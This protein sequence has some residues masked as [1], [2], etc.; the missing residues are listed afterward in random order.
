MRIALVL[1]L[2]AAPVSAGLLSVQGV[3]VLDGAGAPRAIFSNNERIVFQQ[4]IHNGAASANRI[5]FRF[6]VLSPTGSQVFEHA[7]NAVPGSVG[8]A[9]SQVSG[10]P[11]S[12]FYS[13]PGVYTLK[14]QASLDGSTVE[15]TAS[16]TLSSPNILLV[17]PPNGSRDLSDS[18]LTFRWASSGATRY[19]V[20]VGDNPSFYNS[21]FSQETGSGETFLSYPQNPSDSRQRLS[22]GQIYY[23]KVEGLDANGNAVASSEVPFTFSVLSAAMTKDLAVVLLEI[24]P[25]GGGAGVIPF[26]VSVKN[27]GSTT[28]SNV[29]LRFGIGGVPAPGTPVIIPVLNPGE[30]KDYELPASLPP[31]QGESL[32]IACVEIFDDMVP[33]NCKTLTVSAPK[34]PVPGE[35]KKPIFG[36]S[37]VLGPEQVWQ[38]ISELLKE[39]GLTAELD[40]YSLVGME[41]QL[42]SDELAAL[43]DGL[44]KGEVGV[45]LTGPPPAPIAPP[46]LAPPPAPPAPPPAALPGMAAPPPPPPAPAAPSGAAQAPSGSKSA[47]VGTEW[48]GLALPSGKAAQTLAVDS[49][50]GWERLWKRVGEGTPPELDFEKVMVVGILCGKNDP[51]ERVEI[52]AVATSLSGVVV[53]YKLAAREGKAAARGTMPYV[54]RVIPKSGLD[55]KFELLK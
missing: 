8:T 24:T 26:R 44:R 41:G 27:Q 10:V 16:F 28:E 2:L 7:G 52:E 40:G 1:L 35:E 55:V 48:S 21:L 14:A 29:Q 5:V 12:G 34:A 42:N 54:L 22:L 50:K 25:V 3:A 17:Y 31:G 9:A 45:T 33:N 36:P 20:L 37:A 6:T 15:Q 46:P 47:P 49:T 18:P 19:R 13:G 4:R 39:K 53:R 23:W 51:A 32:A 30:S 38:A 43:L 11:I